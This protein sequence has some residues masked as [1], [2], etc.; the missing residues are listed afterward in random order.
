MSNGVNFDFLC[1]P[2]L[3]IASFMSANKSSKFLGLILGCV[4]MILPIIRFFKII[5]VEGGFLSPSPGVGMYLVILFG[6]INIFA[7]LNSNN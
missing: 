5:S 6:V 4:G 3:I 7:A 2:I 1:I